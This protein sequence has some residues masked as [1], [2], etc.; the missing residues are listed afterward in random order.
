MYQGYRLL[1]QEHGTEHHVLEVCGC[2]N[3]LEPSL[4]NLEK[5]GAPQLRQTGFQVHLHSHE[6]QFM[7]RLLQAI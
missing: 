6:F 3:T 5:A 7:L 1:R 2:G 4:Q